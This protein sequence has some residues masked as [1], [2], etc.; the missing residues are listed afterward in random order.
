MS[1]KSYR[2]QTFHEIRYVQKINRTDLSLNEKLG[3]TIRMSRR[4]LRIS[5]EKL[6]KGIGVHQAAI[7]RVELGDQTLTPTQ[8][9][10]CSIMI[11]NSIQ[12]LQSRTTT[13]T[14]LDA[15]PDKE[16]VRI[17]KILKDFDTFPDG[18]FSM[19]VWLRE[20]ECL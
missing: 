19:P 11:K 6:G 17:N 2:K 13:D 5:Q 16:T 10:L 12:Y 8:I 1:L 15:P 20:E 4:I 18:R 14:P 9:R 3:R 7:C